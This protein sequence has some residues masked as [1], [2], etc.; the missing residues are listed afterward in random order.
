MR[1]FDLSLFALG[2]AG[3]LEV[4][5]GDD[6]AGAGGVGG[7]GAAAGSATAGADEGGAGGSRLELC[8]NLLDDDGDDAVDCLDDDCDCGT[9]PDGWTGPVA[10]GD[11][12]EGRGVPVF[13]PLASTESCGCA[14]ETTPC[15]VTLTESASPTCANPGPPVVLPANTCVDIAPGTDGIVV[16]LTPGSCTTSSSL[17]P[18]SE[19]IPVCPSASGTCVQAE[20][21]PDCPPEFPVRALDAWRT[22]E[23][24]RSC[25]CSCSV[26]SC[27]PFV[28]SFG[29]PNCSGGTSL[30]PSTGEC[31]D[32]RDSIRANY[33]PTACTAPDVSPDGE[34]V[35]T[36]PV[37]VCCQ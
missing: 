21:T 2:I 19:S 30:V 33:S 7:G 9:I 22:L 24:Q 20:G 15:A 3:C 36:L 25:D 28:M 14:C 16:A 27:S 6:V 35:V 37:T 23:D 17:P 1:L 12:C 18:G 31:T 10:W 32:G 26:P 29:Q 11:E 4:R 34:V 5:F 13:R 8:D